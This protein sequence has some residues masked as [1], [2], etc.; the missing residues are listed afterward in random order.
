MEAALLLG[1]LGEPDRLPVETIRTASADRASAVPIFV[2]AIERYLSAEGDVPSPDALFFVFHLLSEWREKS[3]YRPLTRLLRRREEFDAILGDA[4]TE[5]T[6]RVMAAVFDGDPAPVYDV[7]LDSK[8]DEFI[9][10][11]MCE[12]IAMVTLRGELP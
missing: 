2:Q 11:R 7:I 10:S 6:H 1:Q 9:R 5:T 8:V 3:A 12:A 4:V